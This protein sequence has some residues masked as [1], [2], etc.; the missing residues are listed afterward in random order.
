MPAIGVTFRANGE[1][2]VI[3]RCNGCGTERQNRVAA[4]DNPIALMK[5]P[6]I[7]PARHRPVAEE[8]IA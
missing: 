3:H 4:D 8:E 6:P 5:L 1:Q 7:T 2:M